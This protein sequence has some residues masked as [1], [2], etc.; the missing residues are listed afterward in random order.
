MFVSLCGA[1]I[2]PQPS[3]TAV[4]GGPSERALVLEAIRLHDLGDYPAAITRLEKLLAATP[5]DACAMYELSNTL[6]AQGN[7]KQALATALKAAEYNCTCLKEIHNRIASSLDDLGRPEEALQV[8]EESIRL[9][10]Q[11]APLRFNQ[12]IT[13]YRLHRLDPAR[14][15]LQE[16]VRLKPDYAS[17]HYVLGIVY[18]DSRYPVPAILAF[19]RFL[20]L[21]PRGKRA[22]IA[23]GRL[24][25]GL[26]GSAQASPDGKN[27]NIT[28]DMGA[29]E[30]TDEGDFGGAGLILGLGGALRHVEKN[31]EKSDEEYLTESLTTI[32]STVGE[33]KK[34]PKKTQFAAYYYAPYFS[35]LS[36]AGY[37]DACAWTALQSVGGAP[38]KEWLTG[39]APA[40]QAWQQWSE[41][42]NW[43]ADPKDRKKQ[44]KK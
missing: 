1:A 38:A 7:H 34:K 20:I 42:W 35:A 2:L 13:L 43:L 3:K 23:V 40:V 36:D 17:A 6:A 41:Q 25:Q 27:I 24:K 29:M 10:P 28:L 32:W 12:A 4:V 39:H 21:E 18:S 33:G 15:A 19:S 9:H 30:K 8:Y 5:D 37:A 26:L 22:E 16:A 44:K 31:K 14:A 11:D